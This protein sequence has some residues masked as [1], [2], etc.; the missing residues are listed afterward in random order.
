MSTMCEQA[1]E[2]LALVPLNAIMNGQVRMPFAPQLSP[3][4]PGSTTPQKIIGPHMHAGA[5]SYVRGRAQRGEIARDAAA[6]AD[7]TH[8]ALR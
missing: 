7:P 8:A 3:N 4:T 6:N 5:S 1:L 2:L